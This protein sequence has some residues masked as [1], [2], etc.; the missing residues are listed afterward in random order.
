[1]RGYNQPAPAEY[2][3]DPEDEVEDCGLDH[4]AKLARAELVGAWDNG[5]ESL[6][7]NRGGAR[8]A[9]RMAG[10]TDDLVRHYR[11]LEL[12]GSGGNP[13]TAK[14]LVRALREPLRVIADPVGDPRAW[15]DAGRT[16]GEILARTPS[17]QLF[18]PAVTRELGKAKAAA[19]RD[20]Y[21]RRET[22]VERNV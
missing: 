11:T 6:R 10:H 12:S 13:L 4:G 5:V 18:S 21:D 16:V 20:L 3:D 14:A 22:K 8:I 1:M 19:L 2:L 17:G 15:V 9:R 7:D